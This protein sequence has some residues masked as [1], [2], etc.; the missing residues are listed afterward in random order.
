MKTH[1]DGSP[2]SRIVKMSSLYLHQTR[3]LVLG[4]QEL[5]FSFSMSKVHVP[6]AVLW[7]GE[8]FVLLKTNKFFIN[9]N[10]ISWQKSAVVG[11]YISRWFENS[12]QAVIPFSCG[13]FVYTVRQHW[14]LLKDCQKAVEVTSLDYSQNSWCPIYK[15][16]IGARSTVKRNWI[17]ERN[18][19]SVRCFVWRHHWRKRWVLTCMSSPRKH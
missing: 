10:R 19:W 13:M 8:S 16:G 18:W 9:T 15:F 5:A 14:E 4:L 6:M 17:A 2:W 1:T 11:T 3:C 7:I 12:S